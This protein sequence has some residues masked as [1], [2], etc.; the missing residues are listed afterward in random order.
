MLI[1]LKI[2]PQLNDQWT[3]WIWFCTVFEVQEFEQTGPDDSWVACKVIVK[4]P[5]RYRVTSGIA[6][7]QKV[8]FRDCGWQSSL[9]VAK[10]PWCL[11]HGVLHRAARVPPPAGMLVVLKPD[12]EG[13]ASSSQPPLWEREVIGAFVHFS[14]CMSK[15]PFNVEWKGIRD[16]LF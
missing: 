5:A 7:S 8:D 10:R 15:A 2:T 6:L 14:C 11:P 12:M 4:R 3:E 1:H 9:A 13:R 16:G